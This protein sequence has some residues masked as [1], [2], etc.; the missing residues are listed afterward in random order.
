M[1][2]EKKPQDGLSYSER[3]G[4]LRQA[5][6]SRCISPTAK[7]R[8]R[9]EISPVD[10]G[11]KTDW[12]E[13]MEETAPASVAPR[14][15]MFSQKAL[16]WILMGT[17]IFFAASLAIFFYYFTIGSGGTVASP[18]NIEITVRG[19]VN[20]IGGE[21]SAFQIAV[22]NH[23]QAVLELADLLIKY[24]PGTRSPTDFITDLPQQRI[25][26]GSIEPGGRRQGRI[27]CDKH[28]RARIPRREFERHLR[29]K[30]RIH[31]HLRERAHLGRA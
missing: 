27:A 28:A 1:Q 8:P 19:P 26:L 12:E 30:E 31:V 11:V 9:H 25:S 18:G 10:Y 13:D 29:C 20:V 17:G 6:Y 3:L 7:M 2:E 15:I 22:T 4:R 5:M 16:W 23:N 21:P 24:P 14:V